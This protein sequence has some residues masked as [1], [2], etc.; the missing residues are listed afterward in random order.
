M[1]ALASS[2]ARLEYTWA[3]ID[4]DA[5]VAAFNADDFYWGTGYEAHRVDV[6]AA[7][8]RTSSIHGI[9]SWQRAKDSL[10]PE[11]SDQW[12]TRYRVEWRYQF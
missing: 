6:G 3:K 12:V 1:G 4:Q 10:I 5:T 7:T 8:S 9:A 11:E 2:R